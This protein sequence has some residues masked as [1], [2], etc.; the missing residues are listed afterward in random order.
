[1]NDPN[2]MIYHKGSYHL[3]YQYYPGGITWG[4]MHWGHATSTDLYRWQHQPVAL[5]PDSLGYIFS[6]SAVLDVGNTSGLGKN[7]QPPL[8]AIY[9]YHDT[10]GEKARRNDFQTQGIAYSN[11]DGKTWVK[12]R[13]NPVLR[14][15]GIVDFRDPKVMWYA[16]ARKWIM[17]LAAKDRIAFYSSPNL[18]DWH[19]ESD[20]GATL[21]AHGGVW[22]CP[23]LFTLD[24]N[25][26]KR[27]VLIVNINPG[28]PNGGSGTQYFVGDFDG[29]QFVPADTLTRWLDYG[30]DEY[31]GIT[32]S[33]TGERR[34]FLGWMSNWAYAQQV[35][36]QSW[37]SAMTIPRDLYLF[38][39]G[40]KIF[41]GS[42]PSPELD[43]LAGKTVVLQ[44]VPAANSMSL[45]QK[46]GN[47]S[48]PF[49]LDLKW[50]DLD[51]FAI[52]MGNDAGEQVVAGFDKATQRFYID[53]S[54]S[55]K[56]DFHNEF[57]GRHTAPRF[58]TGGA[59]DLTLVVDVASVEL[60]ADGGKTVMTSIFFPNK[61]FDQVVLKTGMPVQTVRY[62]PLKPAMR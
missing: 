40:G 47:L 14:N 42:R 7:G 60:F 33:N 50:K 52:T 29:K 19:K 25:G 46:T 41:A 1:M 54:R 4:P 48:L 31:A 59:G 15:P 8:V 37:R 58:V 30:P 32:W 61:P 51:D 49:R 12:Y 26:K 34:I 28:A 18:K 36:T 10:V 21:G 9:T 55:G 62:T 39:A 6:G 57:A 45:G 53:R 2:G 23:D 44:N 22:E 24:H 17:T 56:T 43:R 38:D 13:G 35:P 11:D 27:W 3:F 5:Y 20:F 16:P